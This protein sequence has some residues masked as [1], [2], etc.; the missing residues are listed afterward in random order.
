MNPATRIKLSVM[1]FLQYAIWSVWALMLVPHLAELKM[2]ESSI[3]LIMACGGLGSIFGPFIMGQ[4]ADRYFA[5]EKVLAFCHLTGGFLL[6]AASYFT[7]FW[8]IFLLML[9]YCSLYFPTV[10]L[11]NSLTF[12]AL[13][14]EHA[15]LFAPI[16]LWGTI[17]WLLA[18]FLVGLYLDLSSTTT[19]VLKPFFDLVGEPGKYEVLRIPGLISLAFGLYCFALPHTPPIAGTGPKAA[20]QLDELVELAGDT[21]SAVPKKSAFIESLELMKDRSFAILLLVSGIFG[22]A[23]YYYFQCEGRFLPAVGS[24]S[25]KVGIQM[26]LG[27]VGEMTSMALVPFMVG[28]FSMKWTMALGGLAYVVMFALNLLGQPWALMVGVNIL[29]GFCFGFLFV[30]ASMYVD[31]AASADIKASAQSLFVFV[32]YGL[33]NVVGN[34][35]AGYIRDLLL[36]NWTAIWAIPLVVT[37]VFLLVFV[38]LFREESVIEPE[39]KVEPAA[40]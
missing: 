8:P 25:N 14:E 39:H 27:Q 34:V 6:I 9:V 38:A 13:G 2:S 40:A 4:L 36:P 18:T 21:P 3:G 5:T 24:N 33:F 11:T 17:G 20:A 23:L 32:V 12:R 1:M 10:G 37:A 31:K 29:H 15:S 19:P 22:F 28:R 26:T 30:V 16:R 7:S 35:G